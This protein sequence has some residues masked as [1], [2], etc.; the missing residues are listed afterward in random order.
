MS[1][2]IDERGECQNTAL[3]LYSQMRS[4]NF[5]QDGG[6]SRSLCPTKL[7]ERESTSLGCRALTTQQ[8]PRGFVTREISDRAQ[9]F[10]V[11]ACSI[12]LECVQTRS[13]FAVGGKGAQQLTIK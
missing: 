11:K 7:I 13:M 4:V 12:L 6:S 5:A 10:V 3:A 9:F 2:R 8:H 1:S